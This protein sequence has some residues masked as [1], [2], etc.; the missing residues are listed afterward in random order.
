MATTILLKRKSSASGAPS[1]SD[2]QVGELAINTNTGILYTENDAGSII[3]IGAG[4]GALPIANL[5]IDAGT[6]IGAGLADADLFI[7]DDGAGGTNRKTAAS[8]IKTYVA[9]VTLTTAAQTNITSLGTLTALTVDDVAVN[10]KVITMTG[11]TGDTAALTVGTNGT[12]TI[13]TTDAAAAAANI[14]ITADGTVDIDSAGVLTLDSG[15]AINIEPASGSAILL[16]GTISIDAGVVTGAT[17]ITSTAFVGDITGDVTGNV[18]GTA[19]T[20]TTA[21]QSNITSLGTLTT[22]TV[23]NIIINGTNIGHTSD[24]DAIAISSGGVVTFSQ[25]PVFPDGSIAI[26]DLDIDGG[27]DIGAGVVDADLFIVDD[28]AGGTNRKVTASRIKTYIGAGAADDLGAGDAAVT[29]TTTS[30]DITI[31]AQASDSDIIFKGTD[32]SSDTT[33]LTIDGSAAGKATFNNEIV[34]GAVITSGA[35]L[36][37]ADAGNIGSASDTDAI[38]IASD[39]VVTMNQIPVFSAGIN[40]SGGTIAGTLAT[41]AQTNITSLGTLTALT[42]D[43]VAVNGK[44]IT[45]TGSSSDTAVFTVGTNGTLSIVTTDDAAAAANIQITADGTVD[46]DSAGVLTLDSGAAINI[47]PASGSAILLDGTISIDAG[48]VTGATSITSTA[49]VG[50]ITGDV[51]GN[52]SGTA[53]TV[54]TAAQ[55]NITSLGT[56]T[57][58]TV[59]D[60]AINGKVITMTGSSSDTAVFT[61]GTNGTLS[62]VT[63]DDAAAAA[64]IQITAD[65]TAELAGTTVTLDSAGGITLDADN[66]T[67]TFADAGSSLGTITSSGYSGTAA[68]AT[69]VTVSASTANT[70]FPVVFHDE[71]NALL[72]DTGALRYNPSTGELLVPN[73]TVAGTTTQVDTVTMQ[74]ANAVI[75]EGATA[76]AHETTLSVVDP[77]ADHTQYLINQGGYIPLLAAATTTAITSTPA[78]LN[79]LDGITA[80]TVSAS[81][82]VIVDSNKDITGFRNVTLSGELDAATGDFS[83]A[84]DVAGATTTAALTASGILKTDDTTEAT[85]TT[86]GSLQTDGGLSVVKDAVFGDDVKL[87]SDAAVLSFGADSDVTITHVADTGILLNSTMAIQFNDASQSINAP[88]NAILDINATDEIELNA[89][90]ADVNANLDVSGTIVGA[91]TLTATAITASGILKTDDTTEATS[92]TDGSLQT[93]GGLSVAKDIVAGDDVK[94]LSDAAVLSFGA[95]SDVTLT[96]VADTGILL[97]STMA[98]QFN[99]ASQYINAPSNAILDINATDEIELNATLADVN[100]NLDV[101]GTLN[102]AGATTTAALTAS[103][104]LKTDDT[105]E[106]TST[107][108]GSLQTDGGLSVAKDVV[109]GDDV[110]LLSDAA[111]LSFGADSDVTITH[112]AD[113][114]ILLNSTMAIQFNDASQF[115]NAPSNAI[116]DI[117]AT[118]EIELNATLADVNANLDVSGT[119]VGASTLTA[120][121]ITASGILKT[122][123]TTEATSTTDGSLQT[124]GGLS[125]A[126]DIVAGDDVKLLSD[127]AVLSFGADSDVTITHVADTGILLNSTMA[128]QFND[129]S[130]FINAP[131]NAILDINATDEIELNATLADVNA[132]LDVSGTY[133]GGG[134][135]TTGGN[136]V[137]PD[138]GNI[139]SASDTDAISISSGGV[140]TFSQ[141][142]IYSGD[143]TFEDDVSLDSDAAVLS[144]G[145]DNEITITHV[146]DKGLNLK[147]T[148]TGDDKPIIFTLQTGETDIAANDVIGTINF[149]APDEGQG[150]DAIL[151]AAGIE[152]VSEGDFSSSNNATKLV[153]K[154]AAS[155][156]AA[157]KMTLSSAGVLTVSGA[158]TGGGLLTTGGNIVI[159]DAGDIGSASDTDAMSISS[160]GVV[161]FTARPTFAAS[162]TIQDGGSIGSASDLNAITIS[163]GGVVAVTATTANTSATDGALTVAGGAGVA[164][165]LSVGDDLRLI[166]DAAVLSFGAD[167][168]VTL[169]HVA[170]T[171]ILLNSTMAIQ[172]NDASQYIN[173]P[174]N[175]ILDI[176]A[177]DEIE[178]N[179]TLVDVNANLDVSGTIVGASTLTATAITAS[180][181]LKTDDTT[182]AT[183]TTDGSLQ[184][185]GG[186]SVA[187]DVVAGDDV[188]LL[189]DAAVLSFGADS[190]VTLTHVADT[191]ILLNSTMAIQFN[192]ASHY[193]NA[194]SNAILDINA[195]DEIELNATL[196]DVN[197]N[198]D[199]SGTI[200]G[201]STLTATAITASGIL[202]TDDTTEATSTTDGSLQT[203]GGLSVAKDTVMGDDLKLLSDAS[204]IHFGANSEITLTHVH[205][206]GLNLK[207]TATADDKPIVLTLQTGETDMAANDVMGAI[208]FQAPD[209]GQGTDAILVAAAIQAVAEGDF[210]S[211]NNAT[212]LEFHTGASEAASS[213][214]TLSSAGLL[215]IADDLMIKDGGTIGVASTNDAITISSAGIVTFKDDILIKDGGTI[216]VASTAD[217]MTV[218][219]AGIVTFKDDILI[220]D[221][222]TIGSASD[223]DAIAIASDGVVTFSQVPVLPNNTVETADIQDNAVTLA[224]MAGLARGKLIIGDASGDPSALAAGSNTYVL[225]SDGTDISWAAPSGGADPSS[226]DGDS[227]GTASAEWSDL[228]LADGGIIYF[229]NDQE[230]TLTHV[231]DDGLVLKHVGTG[232]GKEPSFSFHAGDNDIAA[233]DV[234]GS[235][236]FKAPD[237]GAG[238]D[239]VLVA[240]GLE[241]VSEGDFSASNNAT[242]LSFLTAASEAAAEKMSLS[243]AGLL[244]VSGR[245]ITDDTT[246]ATSTTDGSLQTDGGLSVAKDVV[247]GDDVKLL[248]DAA[249]LSFGADSDV[250]LTTV[251][252]TGIL[253]NSTMAIQFNDA[254]QYINAPSNAILDIN[255]TDEIELNA[256][257]ADV[258]ANLDVSGTYTG[259]GLMTTGG[260]IVIPDGGDIG[261]A[262]DTD[263]I[264]ISSG[265]AVTF[266]QTPVFPDGSIAIADL[267]IDGGTDIGAGIADADLFIID[268]NAGG[269]N[270]KVA[271]SRLKTYV[272]SPAI[273]AINNATAN[274]LVTVGSTTTELDAEANLTYDGTDLTM[275]STDAGAGAG[276][277]LTINRD[278]SSPADND[279]LGQILFKGDDSG[280]NNDTAISITALWRDVTHAQEDGALQF[281]VNNGG[282]VRNFLSLEN[283]HA[284]SIN[285]LG[286]V[287]VNDGENYVNFR[288]KAHPDGDAAE[289]GSHEYLFWTEGN[290]GKICNQRSASRDANINMCCNAA[291]N[292]HISFS[293]PNASDTA[294]GNINS[295]S[296]ATNYVTSSDYRMKENITTMSGSDAITR[297]KQLLPKQFNFKTDPDKRV[298][299]FIAHEVSGIV[300]QAVSGTKDEFRDEDIC[301]MLED[302]DNIKDF[303]TTDFRLLHEDGDNVETE[304]LIMPQS[305][306][307]SKMV[308]VLVAALKEAIARI[309]VLES[310]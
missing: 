161:N 47:E 305:L 75:F 148:A 14:Q 297:V 247:A 307:H 232:D 255:A 129:A 166:S 19:A 106:A 102:V 48:V 212:T 174:S 63:T 304:P 209:E 25:N 1:T 245:I 298:D 119:I 282:T 270:R 9:D 229:G 45:M 287:L 309:E 157:S 261:S 249:V 274:E 216:G 68:V 66:G 156:A 4:P 225:T 140:V 126:K 278:S 74:A 134:L 138:G 200:V 64:N 293:H 160:G 89:T 100:A 117:N 277:I 109:A 275:T 279:S 127:A 263:A 191:G 70:N 132:N 194:P 183:S 186:L 3:T 141:T 290:T 136:I 152:A 172:F 214:M 236:F 5:D 11:S 206:V 137:I 215:T 222:G 131:S 78:E 202:K 61:V 246:E 125:V 69:T 43:D 294:V 28:G 135:M 167:S 32:D 177:T 218:S 90:L 29:L 231:A 283:L 208:R 92:T 83:G 143:A 227:L 272:G 165:D 291:N 163:S 62:I 81:L 58:L 158:I 35:G 154:T 54:T 150:T 122:D 85:S 51:T 96:H 128:I 112:V 300:D 207:H 55:T 16:D 176:N 108:D 230:I 153:F 87:L 94:L 260:N 133:T 198:L 23:D 53:A 203:D 139:G 149:Q 155:E 31:D 281:N 36:V 280:G 239:A 145:E 37:I 190:D 104:I 142:P 57:A 18:S 170:D 34:S 219:S 240:A 252:D 289:S 7:V 221:G 42:V 21:A 228:Y 98:I 107:T 168:D 114:G 52:V 189:S 77:T 49:F 73:L 256:T 151:V 99:D 254:S 80:G 46:I 86:D 296:S 258:N 242:K 76:D 213:K 123:D 217:A 103:G 79:L 111:V 6:D 164:A 105:T 193:I 310:A 223:A 159:P 44:V 303:Y 118:D 50:D 169:T 84:V 82:A 285:S 130:Q 226:A 192:D 308:P 30:G 243:S 292:Q 264:S 266:T 295:T 238:T 60:V 95:D 67:I 306:D 302:A 146:A 271:A 299:G 185:D 181:I 188:K 265:G 250:T 244:T 235:I 2:L 120:T 257:L 24:T 201:A 241:A 116:L 269:T 267:D 115:I 234:L 27:T 187:K 8:R 184:T 224:K 233:N 195:T 284:S 182:E 113:T 41:A 268:D 273:T 101:S 173:A 205:D 248:S 211:S 20:V 162:L 56:L 65:G 15:A 220:K 286:E 179:A 301:I 288:V 251:A 210:S 199:V 39:G 97:N 33:F 124:D 71:S 147:H 13:E 12:L 262:S 197:A 276:P 171:G 88:S 72:D 175:A 178:L 121:A 93:D 237:E 259:G 196:A 253:L 59:D 204:V 10:G 38:A 40:V 22:L 180:G 26:A 144:F 17:S 110:K 91:S